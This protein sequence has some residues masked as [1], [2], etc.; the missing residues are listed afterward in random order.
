MMP[1][2]P[3][4]NGTVI[5]SGRAPSEPNASTVARLRKRREESVLPSAFTALEPPA[6]GH[7]PDE[8]RPRLAARVAEIEDQREVAVVDRDAGDIDDAGNAL[9]DGGG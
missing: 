2:A 3:D 4:D 8:R 1:V 7:S 5:Y 9:L 6:R